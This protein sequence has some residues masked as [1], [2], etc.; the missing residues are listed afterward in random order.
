MSSY[1]VVYI[2][3]TADGTKTFFF[4]KILENQVLNLI[5]DCGLLV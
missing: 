3:I 4:L 1:N 2:C 5:R